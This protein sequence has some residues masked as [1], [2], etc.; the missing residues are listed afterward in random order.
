MESQIKGWETITN[1]YQIEEIKLDIIIVLAGGLDE[2]GKLHEWVIRRLKRAI[3]LHKIYEVPILCCGGGTYHK[4]PFTNTSGFVVHESTECV[5]YLLQNGIEKDNIYRE[6]SS[7]DTIA[8]AFFSLT[9]HIW[10]KNN[11]KGVGIVTSEFHMERTKSIFEWIYNLKSNMDKKYDLYNY[12]VSDFGLGEDMLKC[13]NE[14][15]RDSLTNILKLKERIHTID[16][17]SKWLYT[18]HNAYNNNFI[19]P[20]NISEVCRK[21]Y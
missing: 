16:D 3:E 5:N 4:P 7:Y 14:R 1:K 17:F 2:K 13:R 20:E 9:T 12:S 6:W 10:C 15:E 11:I 8:N 21:S 19:S 18:E